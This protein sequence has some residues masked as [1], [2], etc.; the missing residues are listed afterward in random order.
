MVFHISHK[1]YQPGEI[2]SIK[3]YDGDS[4]Y[5]QGLSPKYKDINKFLSDGKPKGMPARELC[6]YAFDDMAYCVYFMKNEIADGQNLH[7]YKCLMQEA[8]GHPMILVGKIANVKEEKWEELRNEYWHPTK[9]WKV[10]EYM[11]EEIQIVEK[12]E[13]TGNLRTSS[14]IKGAVYYSDDVLIANKII[15]K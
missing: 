6:I 8:C 13:I 10:M 2:V 11:T 15:N 4:Y 5:H 14:K 7:L 1:I 3:N 9:N 12:L